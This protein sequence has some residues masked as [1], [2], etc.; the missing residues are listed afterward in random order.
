MRD[1]WGWQSGMGHP[2]SLWPLLTLPPFSSSPLSRGGPSEL[3]CG[4]SLS[5]LPWG[6]CLGCSVLVTA[7]CYT[8]PPTGPWHLPPFT[9]HLQATVATTSF[10]LLMDHIKLTSVP[11]LSA[12]QA[13]RRP[14]GN[15]RAPCPC[16]ALGHPHLVPESHLLTSRAPDVH[17][18]VEEPQ[19]PHTSER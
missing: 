10:V 16:R 18:F 3:L 8:T 13:A 17:I 5:L 2:R 7:S 11:Y 6:C 1:P 19:Q 4:Q 12:S 9:A 15:S 14:Q